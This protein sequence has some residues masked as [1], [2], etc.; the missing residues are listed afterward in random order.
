MSDPVDHHYLAV[1]YLNRWAGEDGKVCRFSRP[2]GDKVVSKRVSARG[3]GYEEHL[4]SMR[5]PDGPPIADME[6]DFMSRLDSEAA[7]ALDLLEQ[8]LPESKWEQRLRSAWSR[9]LWAQSIRTPSEIAQLKL[10]VKESWCAET[11]GLQEAYEAER[12]DGAPESVDDWLSTLDP[13]TEDRFALTIARQSMDHSSIGQIIN[14]MRWKV[15]DFEG[16]GIPLLTSDRPVWMTTTL[17]ENDA[18]ILMPIAPTRLFVATRETETMLRIAA[19]N[20]RQQAKNMNKTTVQHAIKFVFGVDDKMKAF[21]QK[22]FAARRHSTHM[23]RLAA[24]R[25]HRIA[26]E[27]SPLG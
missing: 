10:S 22:H 24:I 26:A 9:F 27:D 2:H 1:F 8:G 3:T 23:E 13:H 5:A 7:R 16:C 15:L 6:R 12:P 17:V 11:P 4:Y 20:R 25:G 19:Q 21:V 18:F 14:N